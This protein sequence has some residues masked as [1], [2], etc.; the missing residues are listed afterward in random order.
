MMP[1]GEVAF[2][3]GSQHVQP[4]HDAANPKQVHKEGVG[5]GG[6]TQCVRECEGANCEKEKG[7]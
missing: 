1:C 4:R 2:S 6:R 5:R 7:A 3:S